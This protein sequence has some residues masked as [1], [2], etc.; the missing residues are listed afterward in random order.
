MRLCISDEL[1]CFFW[2]PNVSGPCWCGPGR[3]GGGAGGAECRLRIVPVQVSAEAAAGPRT[4]VLPTPLLLPVLLPV[5][6]LWLC[7]RAH[8]VQ[9]L[10]WFQ[11]SG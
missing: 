2:F 3:S 7:S 11:C 5:Q 1:I 10:Q 9:L 6:D 4:L 8:M